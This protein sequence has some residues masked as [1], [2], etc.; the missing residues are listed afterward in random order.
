[1]KLALWYAPLERPISNN[2]LRWTSTK[3]PWTRT[4]KGGPWWGPPPCVCACG[5]HSDGLRSPPTQP[6]TSPLLCRAAPKAR[7]SGALG[8]RLAACGA[9][10]A[11]GAWP[12]WPSLVAFAGL[13]L[14]FRIRARNAVGWGKYSTEASK[15][16]G[17]PCVMSS[18]AGD[19]SVCILS[20][21]AWGLVTSAY[22]VDVSIVDVSWKGWPR[23]FDPPLLAHRSPWCSG[24]DLLVFG[25]PVSNLT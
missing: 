10:G 9:C 7:A 19:N 2:I 20:C 12:L 8:V 14:K 4:T 17:R 11:C 6:R 23:R 22:A 24:P 21:K 1:M 18:F 25:L 15:V 16:Q 5:V 3:F 13:D